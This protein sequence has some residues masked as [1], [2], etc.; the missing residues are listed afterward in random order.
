M[1]NL[2]AGSS[3]AGRTGGTGGAEAPM[4]K[5]V[6]GSPEPGAR[7]MLVRHAVDAA[8]EAGARKLLVRHAVDTAP[9]AGARIIWC[10]TQ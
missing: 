3:A 5:P 10:G 1:V 9:E 2:V 4:V 8:P 7:N 6:P